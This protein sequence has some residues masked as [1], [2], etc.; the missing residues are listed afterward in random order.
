MKVKY[1][2]GTT[3]FAGLIVTGWTLFSQN[4]RTKELDSPQSVTFRILF[5][6]AD[7]APTVWDGKVTITAGKV[8]SIQGWRFS[9]EDSSD[10][11]STWKVSTRSGP[12]RP[13]A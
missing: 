3:V 4:K 7:A 11:Q 12:L 6:I 5:G 9:G 2:I 10:Y 13:A 8:L 1:W